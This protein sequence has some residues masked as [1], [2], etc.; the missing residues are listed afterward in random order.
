[1][2]SLDSRHDFGPPQGLLS[3]INVTPFID[4]MLVLLIIFM[5][6]APLMMVGVP[7]K[8]PKTTAQTV[9]PPHQPVVVS[10]TR[11]GHLF[12]G[13]EETS[14]A[15][16][17]ESLAGMVKGN[18][19]LV[20]YVRADKTV[21]YGSIMDLLGKVGAGGVSRLSLVAEGQTLPDGTP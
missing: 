15:M 5:V 6:A 4:V 13:Q 20:V 8:L 9:S 11:D 7:L 1:M 17:S 19:D 14:P 21:D 3:E 12:V 10:L 16:L 18:P 2:T